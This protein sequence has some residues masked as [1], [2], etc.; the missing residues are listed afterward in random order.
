MR[1]L[2]ILIVMMVV[3]ITKAQRPVQFSTWLPLTTNGIDTHRV[4]Y[5][6]NLSHGKWSFNKYVSLSTGYSFFKGGGASFVAAPISVQLNR[7]IS[8]HLSAF[9]GVLVAPTYFNFN[10][11]FAPNVFMK[12]S[13][14]NPFFKTNNLNTYSKVELGLMYTNEAKTFSISGS[15]GVERST[16]P[17]FVPAATKYGQNQTFLSNKPQ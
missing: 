6:N 16:Y 12:T 5:Y 11:A 13:A 4:P 2:M 3:S 9:A 15:I 7:S 14:A 1:L 17:V 8:H 10:S